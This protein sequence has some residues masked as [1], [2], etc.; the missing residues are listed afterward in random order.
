MHDPSAVLAITDPEYFDFE[1]MA[2]KVICNGDEIGRT[3]PIDDASRPLV[4]VAM[5]VNGTAVQ[6]K[7]IELVAQSDKLRKSRANDG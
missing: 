2:L 4:Q 1:P 3:L 7:F 6:G 5:Q